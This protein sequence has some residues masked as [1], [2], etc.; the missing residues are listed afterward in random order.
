[1]T[2]EKVFS[3]P[4]SMGTEQPQQ[5]LD[6]PSG[7]LF[8]GNSPELS[9]PRPSWTDPLQEERK[10]YPSLLKGMELLD[11]EEDRLYQDLISSQKPAAMKQ[12]RE[13]ILEDL[14]KSGASNEELDQA[15]TV[16]IEAADKLRREKRKNKETKK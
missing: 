7:E 11:Y 15:R 12:A 16:D 14:R 4:S 13:W 8:Y 1:M 3:Y 6:H 10:I 9:E 5:S 2:D